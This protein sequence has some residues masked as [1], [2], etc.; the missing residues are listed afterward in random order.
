MTI[1]L[2]GFGELVEMP[3]E[4][5]PEDLRCWNLPDHPVAVLVQRP[6]TTD[7][8]DLDFIAAVVRDRDRYVADAHRAAD[9]AL[10]DRPGYAPDKVDGPELSFNP[11]R[12]WA[13]RFAE[14]DVPGLDELGVL[15][16]FRGTE[17]VEVDDLADHEWDDDAHSHES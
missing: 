5:V 3:A 13:I 17:V 7:D 9:E 12:D 16:A 11:G 4:D 6:A 15:V 2:P 1:S 8:L 14:V 10:R